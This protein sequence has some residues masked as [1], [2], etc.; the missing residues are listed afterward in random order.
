[1]SGPLQTVLDAWPRLWQESLQGRFAPRLIMPGARNGG[2]VLHLRA[3]MDHVSRD[4]ATAL[5][6]QIKA[7]WADRGYTVETTVET[8]VE[9]LQYRHGVDGIIHQVRSD[10]IGGLPKRQIVQKAA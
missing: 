6:E 9:A 2:R 5:A 3:I 4:G 8:T 1:M 7:Y 10:M